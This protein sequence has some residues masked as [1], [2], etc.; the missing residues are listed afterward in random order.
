MS[1]LHRFTPRNDFKLPLMF[2][3]HPDENQDLSM[4]VYNFS[5]LTANV[6]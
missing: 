1:L 2:F 4:L 3:C 6:L 5:Y